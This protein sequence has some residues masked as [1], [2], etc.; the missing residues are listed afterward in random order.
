LLNLNLKICL[1]LSRVF[2]VYKSNCLK[3]QVNFE[4]GGE[5]KDRFDGLLA[6]GG[7][8]LVALSSDLE[9]WSLAQIGN[10]S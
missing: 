8:E 4:H 7:G 3:K 5:L 10:I 9:Y 1:V 2:F 6:G